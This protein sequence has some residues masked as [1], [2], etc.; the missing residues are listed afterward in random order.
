MANSV[1]K[2]GPAVIHRRGLHRKRR[3]WLELSHDFISTF[4]SSGEHDRIRPIKSILREFIPLSNQ[5]KAQID[6][7]VS[8]IKGICPER[9]S[10]PRMVHFILHPTLSQDKREATIEFDTIESARSWRR[11][12][13]GSFISRFDSRCP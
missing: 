10:Q 12:F 3:V 5:S 11:E 13:Q 2:A 6:G 4:P 8:T 1:I 9:P 7:T